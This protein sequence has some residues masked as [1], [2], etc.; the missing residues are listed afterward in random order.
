[1]SFQSC[2]WNAPPSSTAYQRGVGFSSAGLLR[3]FLFI[4]HLPPW[5]GFLSRAVWANT[6]RCHI[7]GQKWCLQ[8]RKVRWV[9]W[10]LPL[11]AD[12]PDVPK[13]AIWVVRQTTQPIDAQYRQSRSIIHSTSIGSASAYTTHNQY[14]QSGSIIHSTSK[15]T[16]CT[17]LVPTLPIINI[18]RAGPC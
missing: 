11:L 7:I 1:M 18:G 13:R 3:W 6:F 8:A 15:G 9:W 16:A 10:Q 4:D 5:P 12:M 14:R 17:A 2:D